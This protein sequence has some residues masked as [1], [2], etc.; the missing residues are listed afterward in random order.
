M[1]CFAQLICLLTN[2]EEVYNL[3]PLCLCLV[4]TVYVKAIACSLHEKYTL[5]SICGVIRGR[6]YF[7]Q[8]SS[9][10]VKYVDNRYTNICIFS[11]LK[12]DL[13]LKQ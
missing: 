11:S 5:Y 12:D 1:L 3:I 10:S 7:I 13:S 2:F 6:Q 4:F 8:L 9:N